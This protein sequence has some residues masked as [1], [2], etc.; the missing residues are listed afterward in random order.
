[1][2]ASTNNAFVV[3]VDST[4]TYREVS[5]AYCDEHQTTR[6][7]TLGHTLAEVFGEKV[8]RRR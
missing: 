1:M 6:E 8:L 2:S 4:Y 7:E 5:Q 3:F